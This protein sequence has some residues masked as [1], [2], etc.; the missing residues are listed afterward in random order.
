MDKMLYISMTG[1]SQNSK[2]LQ[3]HANNLANVS[4]S[5]F[6]RD[7]EQA[8]SM[9]VFGDGLPAR[10]YAMTE[11]PGTD[12]THGTLQETGR[13]LDVAVQGMP[14]LRCRLPTAPKLMCVLPACRSI[15]LAFCV[16]P[17]VCR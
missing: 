7:F 12:F 8:R 5:G 16:L 6:R 9:P 4:T 2:A 10:A 14:G 1:A 11:R 3:A 13:D 15:L 17:A